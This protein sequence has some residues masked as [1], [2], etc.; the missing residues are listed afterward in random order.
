MTVEL[1]YYKR[2]L[3]KIRTEKRET[4]RRIEKIT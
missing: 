1:G 2:V 3:R 4:E